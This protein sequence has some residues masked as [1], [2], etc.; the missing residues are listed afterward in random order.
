MGQGDSELIICDGKTMLIDA[1]KESEALI[2]EQ[3]FD[4]DSDVLKVGHHGS[5][6][7]TSYTFLR[8]VMPEYSV[9]S[10]G[11]NN[12]YGHPYDN[13]LSRLKDASSSI[14]RTD[15]QGDII[16]KSDGKNLTITTQKNSQVLANP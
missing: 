3:G 16:I 1:G 6:Y 13:L 7:S 15:L 8:E 14:Y 9:I 12:I 11:K 4:L 5:D 2:L 10:V